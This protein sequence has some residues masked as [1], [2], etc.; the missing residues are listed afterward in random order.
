[1]FF[2]GNWSSTNLIRTF[3][4]GSVITQVS[5]RPYRH[6]AAQV[7]ICEYHGSWLSVPEGWQCR[8]D[9]RD[10]SRIVH[11]LAQR[12]GKCL[13]APEIAGQFSNG[14]RSCAQ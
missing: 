5:Y 4:V 11:M 2:A 9:A 1:V 6:I 10:I 7:P 13:R 3:L 8:H 14:C 12:V